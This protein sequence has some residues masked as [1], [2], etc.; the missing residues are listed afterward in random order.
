MQEAPAEDHAG[1]HWAGIAEKGTLLGLK[2]MLAAYEV[3]GR[4]LYQPFATIAAGYFGLTSA[5]ARKASYQ[6][7][8][9]VWRYSDGQCGL[10]KKPSRWTSL[11]HFQSFANAVLDK[12]AAWKGDIAY[13]QVDHINL[14]LFESRARAGAGGIWITSHLGNIEVCRAIGQQVLDLKLTVLMHTLHAGNFN[15]LLQQVAPDSNIELLEVTE[16]NMVTALKL[17]ERISKGRF[18][19]IVG[20]RT[21]V[22]DG[23]DS[24]SRVLECPFLG[25]R[26]AFP[27]G[28]YMLATLLDCPAGTLFCV[29]EG[30]RFK[31]FF[32]DLPGLQGIRRAE[33]S[34]AVESA[35]KTFACRLQSLAVDYP[36]QWFNFYPFWTDGA[37]K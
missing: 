2:F 18:I 13:E 21:P 15:K 37:E 12:I 5:D 27:L 31:M 17:Q 32:D 35:A 34:A 23:Q 33:R 22:V 29:R 10:K 6:F 3:A 26:A 7:L 4:W 30:K 19:V 16:F 28:P 25:H 20:D 24:P 36:L 11:S 9:R 1:S 14:D 8:D